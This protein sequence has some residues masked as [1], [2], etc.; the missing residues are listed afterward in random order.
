[1]SGFASL[2]SRLFKRRRP[3]AV[4]TDYVAMDAAAGQA[5]ALRLRDAWKA[6]EIP[7]R[8]R[9]LADSQLAAFRRGE[10]IDVYAAL[11]NALHALP[12]PTAGL[13][14]LE[15]GCSSGYYAE[16]FDIAGLALNYRG[17][18][19]SAAFRDLARAR[20]PHLAFDVE[21]ATALSYADEAYD[22]VVSGCCLLHIP[23]YRQAIAETARVA[24]RYALFH[25]T[26]VLARRE[27]TYYHK[28]AYGVET[29]EIHFNEQ[30]FLG[31]LD[32]QGLEVIG[33]HAL[34]EEHED[35]A[36]NPE[37]ATKTYTTRK[38]RA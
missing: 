17:C 30:E 23:E 15:I 6:E 2:L 12:E 7:L 22:I 33:V 10:F 9:E 34:N 38:R 3:I 25:R 21:D 19:Y 35:A 11:I 32:A 37:P 24:R 13:S 28:R 20:Y 31:L 14:L 18:D 36:G 5:E 26:P 16:A 27:T 4:S 29:V 8:Q 1:M